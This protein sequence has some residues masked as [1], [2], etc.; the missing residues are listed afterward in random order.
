M[1]DASQINALCS[2]RRLLCCVTCA[3]TARDLCYSF[4]RPVIFIYKQL[5]RFTSSPQW[6]IKSYTSVFNKF[7]ASTYNVIPFKCTYCLYIYP[8]T[9]SWDVLTR[10]MTASMQSLTHYSIIYFTLGSIMSFE[11]VKSNMS[12][13]SLVKRF[14]NWLAGWLASKPQNRRRT[15]LPVLLR[16]Q[17]ELLTI[18]C[19]FLF[20]ILYPWTRI[21]Q[22]SAEG[23]AVARGLRD[24]NI[25]V[26]YGQ[27]GRGIGQHYSIS[28]LR[29]EL[30]WAFTAVRARR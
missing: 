14:S 10:W 4:H 30:Q 7:C 25:S 22:R 27:G 12:R 19:K 3:V 13:Y 9:I 18:L 21:R 24:I 8:Y 20:N 16:F 17:S 29:L 11:H 23:C 6:N 2:F 28:Y 26:I 5:P 15:A 1:P